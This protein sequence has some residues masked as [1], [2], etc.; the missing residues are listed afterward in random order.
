GV[1]KMDQI[2]ARI[3]SFV[4]TFMGNTYH[5][6]R[7]GRGAMPSNAANLY[8]Q[9]DPADFRWPDALEA[10]RVLARS[11]RSLLWTALLLAAPATAIGQK[12]E[13]DLES[14]D[15]TGRV[16]EVKQTIEYQRSEGKPNTRVDMIYRFNPDG[17]LSEFASYWGSKVE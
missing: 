8:F 2:I 9:H 1:R 16:K 12:A 15:L 4:A 13:T 5:E 10:R 3:S 17:A 6:L 14:L 7:A 11:A